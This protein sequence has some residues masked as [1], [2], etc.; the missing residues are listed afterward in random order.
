M[1]GK[2]EEV[3]TLTLGNLL[4]GQSATLKQTILSQ[5][6]IVSGY[7]VYSLPGSFCPDYKKHGINGK[8]A[9]K[10]NYEFAYEVKI[11]CDNRISNLSIPANSAIVAQN[12]ERTEI[13]IR[14]SQPSRTM[15]LFYRTYDMVVPQLLY[16]RSPDSDDYAVQISLTQTFDQVQPQ[17]FFEV[18]EDE[19]PRQVQLSNG[20]DFHF[21][22]IVD[23]SFSMKARRRM[24]LAKDA[25]NIFIRSLPVDCKFSIISFGYECEKMFI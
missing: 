7:F 17:D 6:E 23:R 13:T 11:L 24:D 15:D 1:A 2:K 5:L 12:D 9:A 8:G 4:P 19:K 14:S 18:V 20:A 16:A 10:F 25:L 21:I 3:L 22:F